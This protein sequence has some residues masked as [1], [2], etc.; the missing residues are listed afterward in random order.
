[1]LKHVFARLVSPLLLRL[2]RFARFYQNDV[3]SL[4]GR[5]GLSLWLRTF[6]SSQPHQVSSLIPRFD[7]EATCDVLERSFRPSDTWFNRTWCSHRTGLRVTYLPPTVGTGLFESG[8][9]LVN[10]AALFFL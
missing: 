4:S 10:L 3:V 1:M 2:F 7:S 9:N 8:A 6:L 5:A